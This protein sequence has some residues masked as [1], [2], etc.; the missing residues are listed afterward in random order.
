MQ[1]RISTRKPIISI[2]IVDNEVDKTN[3]IKVEN[4]FSNIKE[5]LGSVEKY[6]DDNN[7]HTFQIIKTILRPI[8]FL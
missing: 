4:I 7:V 3:A 6:H 5:F 2:I 1:N 8:I